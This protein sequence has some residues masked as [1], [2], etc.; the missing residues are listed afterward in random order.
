MCMKELQ[1]RCVTQEGVISRLQKRQE[2]QNKKQKQ[3][4]ETIH[5]LNKEL[6][7][8]IEKLKKES[9]LQEKAQ[10]AQ[11]SLETKLMTLREQTEKAKADA[12]VEFRA[13][14]P[15]IDSCAIYYGDGFKDCLKQVGSVYP[16]LDLSKISMDDLVLTTPTGAD[17]VSEEIDNS[18]QSKQDPK[19][20]VV[21][22]AQPTLE[23]LV[24][25]LVPSVEDPP[26][27]DAESP[28]TSDA[29]NPLAQF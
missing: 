29:Q 25:P 14:Q 15:F 5:T 23:G 4:K 11:E 3:Y 8:I 2:I 13:S 9:R 24:A 19:D 20:D 6:M 21:V 22:L 12:I 17:I 26:S 27:K 16:D 7:A 18:T 10:K 1:E 28:S